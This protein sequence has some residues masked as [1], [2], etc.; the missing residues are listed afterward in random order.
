[1]YL[2]EKNKMSFRARLDNGDIFTIF[3]YKGVNV[4]NRRKSHLLFGILAWTD[5]RRMGHEVIDKIRLFSEGHK[6][7]SI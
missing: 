4:R 5:R 1:M 6:D 2:E 7:H 3:L